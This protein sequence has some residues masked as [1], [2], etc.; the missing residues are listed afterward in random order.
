MKQPKHYHQDTDHGGGTDPCIEKDN[1]TQKSIN[2]ERLKV[3]DV[4]YDTAGALSTQEIKFGGEHKVYN[5]KKCMFVWTEENYRR[6]RNLEIT[7]GTELLQTNESVKVNVDKLSKLNKSLSDTLK[8]IAKQTKDIKLKFSDFKDYACKLERC[9]KDKCHTSQVK[10]LTGK[11]PGCADEKPIKECEDAEEILQDLVCIP[12]GLLSD[13]DSIFQSSGDVAGI[14][15]FSNIDTLNPLQKSLEQQ[16]KDFEKHINEVMT[17]RQTDLKKLQ[18]ELVKSVQ[19]I[20]KSAMERNNARSEF[21]GYADAVDFL[22]CPDCGCVPEGGIDRNHNHDHDRTE[23]G[24][25]QD[26][27]QQGRPDRRRDDCEDC[28][29]RLKDCEKCIC[30]I[31][32]EVKKA[33]CC[34]EPEPEKPPA[35]DCDD[36]KQTAR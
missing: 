34:D 11:A 14:Q 25:Y 20:T 31:C 4:L 5:D 36:R 2:R 26:N 13:I 21:E 22:C 10:A 3:C 19:E 15:V 28:E 7:V 8:N 35:E 29:P 27:P 18:D 30:E 16:A 24:R 23:Q 9:L 32:K 12:G 1:A 17:T 33:F 6:Y